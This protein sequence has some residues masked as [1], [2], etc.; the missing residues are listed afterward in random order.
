MRTTRRASFIALL[1]ALSMAGSG[2]AAQTVSG[3]AQ[4]PSGPAPAPSGAAPTPSTP[5]QTPGGSAQAAEERSMEELRNTVINLLQ[6]LVE[7]GVITREQAEAMVKSAQEKAGA[8]AAAAE[9][10]RQAQAKAEEGAVRVPYVPEIV[11]D[12][13]AKEVATELG[14][15]VKQEVVN[16]VSSKGSLFSALPEWVQRMEWSGDIR[17]RGEA[18]DFANTNAQNAYLNYNEINSAGGI[19]KAGA[20]ALLNTTEDQNRLRLRARFGFDADLGDGWSTAMRL[21]TGSTGQ[22]IATTNQ[23]LGTYEEAYTI[24]LNEAMLRWTGQSSSDRQIFTAY[25]GR[26]DDPWLSTDLIWYNDLTFE[27]VI[28]NYRLN[29]SDDNDHR[30]DLFLTLGGIPLTSFSPFDS[31]ATDKQKWL[32]AGQ[33]GADFT[34]D[35]DSRLRFGAAYYDYI[36]IVGMRNALDS[37]L[38]NW[39]APTFVQKGNTMF[40]ISNSSNLDPTLN[41]FGLASNFRIVDLIFVGDLHVLPRYSVGW[42]LE[43]L[44][45]VGFN[46]AEVEARFGSYVAPRTRGYRADLNFGSSGPPQF[47]SW[48]ASVGYRYLERDAVLDAFNDEDFHLGGTDAK[49]YTILYDFNFNP[50]VFLRLKYMAANSI[51]GPPLLIDVGQIDLNARF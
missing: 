37:T 46:T 1:L 44:K 43:A 17:I 38:Y 13:I 18:D 35:N 32:A 29:L 30:H 42:T 12:E 47:G 28:G 6:A 40:D 3:T 41:L 45:N 20:E 7:R 14:P 50:H 48:R 51:D 36:H 16:Q 25:A 26:F 23:T 4:A 8:T 11:K 22:I 10:Q 27:G 24:T 19:S 33:L 49:G 9:Q 21:A 5:A 31:D 15:S 39:T 34:T 2:R